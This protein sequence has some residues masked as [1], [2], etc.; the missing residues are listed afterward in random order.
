MTDRED[1][2]KDPLMNWLQDARADAHV[3]K[4]AVE[5]LESAWSQTVELD[6]VTVTFTT[7][8]LRAL[9]QRTRK[10]ELPEDLQLKPATPES[11]SK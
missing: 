4:S 7:S 3:L 6:R 5:K 8:E 9:L 1:E 11:E 2:P 10:R